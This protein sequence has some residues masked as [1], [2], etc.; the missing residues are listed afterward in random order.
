MGG[1]VNVPLSA[2]YQAD[3]PADARGNAMAIRNFADYVLEYASS[4][5]ALDWSRVPNAITNS[6]D[7]LSVTLD[8]AASRRFYRLRR[9]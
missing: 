3:V 8:A 7:R 5:P 4:L 2:T 9:P 6:G 1:L